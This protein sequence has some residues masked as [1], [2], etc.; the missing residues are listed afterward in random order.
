MTALPTRYPMTSSGLE[1]HPNLS[2]PDAELRFETSPSSGPGGQHVNKTETRVTVIFDLEASQ[3]LS[4]DERERLREKLS[5]RLTKAGEL[6]VSS[7]SHRSQ[8]ANREEALERL[9]ETLREALEPEPERKPTRVPKRA[10]RKRLE[11]K[12]QKAE[13]KRLRKTPEW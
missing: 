1:I 9:A 3:A 7:Q 8:K 12:R 6:R 11:R 13:K 5:S 2:I 10:K 4:G